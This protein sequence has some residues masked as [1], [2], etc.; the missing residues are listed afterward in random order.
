MCVCPQIVFSCTTRHQRTSYL[1][2]RHIRITNMR[3]VS[4]TP[5]L[6]TIL[7][8]KLKLTFMYSISTRHSTPLPV[9]IFIPCCCSPV[10]R[11]LP[12]SH[13]R[14]PHYPP[15]IPSPPPPCHLLSKIL[16]LTRLLGKSGLGTTALA[17]SAKI[18]PAIIPLCDTRT[19]SLPDRAYC[20]M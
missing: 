11:V 5:L 15:I 19:P 2:H 10:P 17:A 1:A 18:V 13:G 14:F 16:S 6:R 9:L 7:G 20:F 8:G 12:K 3:H 4:R